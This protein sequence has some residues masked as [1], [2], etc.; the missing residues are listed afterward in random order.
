MYKLKLKSKKKNTDLS[1]SP[2]K[3]KIMSKHL[4]LK[5]RESK[6]SKTAIHHT[7]TKK[8]KG[9]VSVLRKPRLNNSA[10]YLVFQKLH[11]PA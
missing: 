8:I 6:P 7:V 9:G 1:K 11:D 10:R 5:I 3:G 2:K 4:D